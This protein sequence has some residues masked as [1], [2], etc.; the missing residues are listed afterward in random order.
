MYWRSQPM[1]QDDA[2]NPALRATR[3]EEVEARDDEI[4]WR[5]PCCA[6]GARG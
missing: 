1:P 5:G 2:W 3:Q 4:L 6:A